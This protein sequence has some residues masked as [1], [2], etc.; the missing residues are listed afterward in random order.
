MQ[1]RIAAG[2]KEDVGDLVAGWGPGLGLEP[3]SPTLLL[4]KE[5]ESGLSTDL[6]AGEEPVRSQNFMKIGA[7]M[8]TQQD[9]VRKTPKNVF[10]QKGPRI[11]NF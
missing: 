2:L 7:K 3:G 6:E 10:S 11:L 4:L 5:S 8:A 1:G 9:K